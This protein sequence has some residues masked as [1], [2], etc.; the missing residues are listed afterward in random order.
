MSRDRG[1]CQFRVVTTG[2]TNTLEGL[3]PGKRFITSEEIARQVLTTPRHREQNVVIGPIG[4]TRRQPEIG[5][6]RG[7]VPSQES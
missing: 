6:P 1:V 3:P 7:K 2:L 5:V 4:Q